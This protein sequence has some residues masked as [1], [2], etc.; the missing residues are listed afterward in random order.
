[1]LIGISNIFKWLTGSLLIVAFLLGITISGMIYIV[2]GVF[3][4]ALNFA[5]QAFQS[6]LKGFVLAM[7]CWLIINSVM[8][9]VG[10]KHPMGG[11]WYEFEC[12]TN[13]NGGECD[14][15][16]KILQSVTIQCAEQKETLKDSGSGFF[17]ALDT[18]SEDEKGKTKQLKAIGKYSCDGTTSEE[19]IT[20][21]VEWKASDETQIKVAK[22]L[23]QAVTTSLGSSSESVPYV[24]AKYQEKNSNQAKVYINSCPNTAAGAGATDKFSMRFDNFLI[25]KAHAEPNC[26]GC[27]TNFCFL[28]SCLLCF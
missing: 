2:S 15:K 7:S 5:K 19:D 8:N 1:M 28:N 11:K 9:I 25:P 14:A 23:V 27:H 6:S 13:S 26:E 10:Y 22:G 3:P 20:D 18:L 24:E 4:K 16:N 21:K 12:S 17:V